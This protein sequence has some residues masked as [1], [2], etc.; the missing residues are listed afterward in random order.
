MLH[1][2]RFSESWNVPERVLVFRAFYQRLKCSITSAPS[3]FAR[4]DAFSEKQLADGHVQYLLEAS[5]VDI[6]YCAIYLPVKL[7]EWKAPVAEE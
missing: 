3:G 7:R 6:F 4:N 5:D 1:R 2:A